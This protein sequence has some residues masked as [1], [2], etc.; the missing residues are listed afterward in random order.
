VRNAGIRYTAQLCSNAGPAGLLP[1]S[2]LASLEAAD[3]PASQASLHVASW[4]SAT[5]AAWAEW[6]KP[7][8]ACNRQALANGTIA[9]DSHS[10]TAAAIDRGPARR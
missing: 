8:P 10:S 4:S 1:G 5:C 6:P 9:A 3:A 2:W 7:G